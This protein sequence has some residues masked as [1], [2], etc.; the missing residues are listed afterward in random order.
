MMY[1]EY[2][3]SASEICTERDV[4]LSGCAYVNRTLQNFVEVRC[5]LGALLLHYASKGKFGSHIQYGLCKEESS[6]PAC[7]CVC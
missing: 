1:A 3:Y 7:I 4:R 6:Q 2:R 5:L